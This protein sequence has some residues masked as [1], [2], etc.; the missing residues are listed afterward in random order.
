MRRPGQRDGT[1]AA[2]L[3]DAEEVLEVRLLPKHRL[4][5]G[6]VAGLLVTALQ[7]R[8]AARALGHHLGELDPIGFV[9]RHRHPKRA[10]PEVEGRPLTLAFEAQAALK[11]GAGELIGEAGHAL[12]P[13]R[14]ATNSSPGVLQQES[15]EQRA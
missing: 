8:H 9:Q 1:E 15:G 13:A 6:V 14:W 2:S 4:V 10:K 7:Q 3:G 5:V 12:P 11:V